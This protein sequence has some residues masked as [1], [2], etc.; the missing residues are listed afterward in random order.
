M[1]GAA[2]SLN[3]C[4]GGPVPQPGACKAVISE[5]AI[6]TCVAQF[7]NDI[8]AIVLTG[9]LARDEA[10][11]TREGS[12]WIAAGD[13]EFIVVLQERRPLPCQNED[14]QLQQTVESEVLE[15]GIRCS[16]SMSFAH[17]RYLRSLRPHIFAFELRECG[18]VI[19]GE[20]GILGL[21]PPFPSSSIPREDAWRL[22]ANRIV[23]QCEIVSKVAFGGEFVPPQLQY[24]TIKLYLDMAT[25]LS[26]FAGG[27][28]PTYRQRQENLSRIERTTETLRRYPFAPDEFARTIEACTEWKLTGAAPRMTWDFWRSAV[29]T[30]RALW[31]WELGI[32]AGEERIAEH[33]DGELMRSWM[34]Q[35]PAAARLRGWLYVLRSGGWHRSWRNW[36]R[37]ARMVHRASPRYWTYAAASQIFFAMPATLTADRPLL[38]SAQ[39]Q[40][41]RLPVWREARRFRATN[42]R[43]FA[44]EIAWNYHTYVEKTQS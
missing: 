40:W 42:W 24:A 21:I 37:W 16:I 5:A 22:L 11:F 41:T 29:E 20:L 17:E 26:V 8:R 33:S 38:K 3:M 31:R 1:S 12:L 10:T 15:H 13:A 43:E 4:Q 28:A 32:L 27:Y 6:R 30:A 18:K 44:A 14:A 9:S 34:A 36:P 23:E 39:E 35:Q 25:S 7:G 2:A 19:W